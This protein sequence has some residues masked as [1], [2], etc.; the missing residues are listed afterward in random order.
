MDKEKA[1]WTRKRQLS[2]SD[3]DKTLKILSSDPGT[4]VKGVQRLHSNHWQLDMDNKA[5]QYPMA[6]INQREHIS[7][8]APLT[9]DVKGKN[10]APFLREVL[11][12]SAQLNEVHIGIE[13]DALIL[14]KEDQKEGLGP[15]GMSQSIRQLNETHQV[16]YP[17]IVE[18]EKKHFGN[19]KR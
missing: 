11:C 16:V 15:L 9:P 2:N 13:D 17:K 14:T 3:I 5:G 7:Y 8:A 4:P 10:E 6:V 12:Y 19:K 1:L 18:M